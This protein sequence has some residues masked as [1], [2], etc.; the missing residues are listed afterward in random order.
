MKKRYPF[1]GSA[2]MLPVINRNKAIEKA[3]RLQNGKKKRRI[4]ES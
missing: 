3:R 4:T 1:K 2:E